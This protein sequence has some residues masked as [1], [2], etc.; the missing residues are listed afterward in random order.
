MPN[1]KN[2]VPPRTGPRGPL[3][4]TEI[5]QLVAHS[6]RDAKD[7]GDPDRT[8]ERVVMALYCQL[9]VGLRRQIQFMQAQWESNFGR[10]YPDGSGR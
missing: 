9:P 8:A 7:A 1:D 6:I 10:T 4:A 5:R 3:T 2:E